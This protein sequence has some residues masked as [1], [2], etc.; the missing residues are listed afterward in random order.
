MYTY[1][2]RASGDEQIE[3]MLK[4]LKTKLK[5]QVTDGTKTFWILC[6]PWHGGHPYFYA[7]S[8]DGRRPKG[9]YLQ[10]S[11]DQIWTWLGNLHP[12]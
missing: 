2:R 9:K 7:P 3:K 12:A 1:D 5:V 4:E 6:K 8:L 10:L 11:D